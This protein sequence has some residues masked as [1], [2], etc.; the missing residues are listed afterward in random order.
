[1]KC[2]AC[3]DKDRVPG[4]SRCRDCLRQQWASLKRRQ[5]VG[6]AIDPAYASVLRHRNTEKK[7]R[8]RAKRRALGLSAG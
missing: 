7:R 3:K 6:R 1:M 4:Y 8:Y 2:C 5:T